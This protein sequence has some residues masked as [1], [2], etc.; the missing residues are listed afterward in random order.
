[1][2]NFSRAQTN[3]VRAMGGAKPEDVFATNIEKLGSKD[4][5]LYPKLTM[6]F[7]RGFGRKYVVDPEKLDAPVKKRHQQ[8]LQNQFEKATYD[9][10]LRATTLEVDRLK[11]YEDYVVMDYT[12]EISSALDIYADECLTKD[13]DGSILHVDTDNERIKKV[14][15]NL[16]YD[17]L[18]IDHNLWHWTRNMCKFGNH[19]ILLD[20]QPGKG[21]CGFLPIPSREIKREEAYDGNV[22]S[23]KFTWDMQSEEF[24]QWQIAHFRLLDNMDRYPYGTS[25]IES[26][27]LIWKQLT[28]AEDAMLIYRIT[29]A[30]ERR[31][32]YIDVGN[33]DPGD[34][35]EYIKNIKNQVKRT[36]S[37]DMTTG[38]IDHK[39]NTMAVDED[40]F[41]PRRG[42]KNSEIDTLPGASNL[43]EIADIE[44]MQSKMFAALK[45]PKAYLTFEEEIN[46]KATLSSEDFRFARTINRFQQALIATLTNIAITHLWTLGFREKGQLTEFDLSL[47]NPSTQTEIEKME[48]F[49]QRADVFTSL[50]DETTLSPV[51][52]AWAMQNIFDFTE[53]ETE[54]ILK[55][56]F[57][58]GKMKLEI[59]K[60]SGT[61]P[62]AME[63]MGMEQ[64]GLDSGGGF[65]DEGGKDLPPE[66]PEG[67]KYVD[68]ETGKDID[69]KDDEKKMESYIS[70]IMDASRKLALIRDGKN[71][72]P[73]Q[74]DKRLLVN[75]LSY[76]NAVH[77]LRN[78]DEELKRDRDMDI[79]MQ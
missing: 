42:E 25:A 79:R 72:R 75:S 38:N 47:T 65:Q 77:M 34:V 52:Y 71:V 70:G 23:V 73:V 53:D 35:G 8:Q 69:T 55:Q 51:S 1:M 59:E 33:I 6:L 43:D 48:I 31:V 9:H 54:L 12:P 50:W 32:F 78:L 57:L 20:V 27:R 13:Q 63:G 74:V 76:D 21:V 29:R 58:E 41:I 68:P 60:A 18:D 24:D 46:A 64:P 5:G 44:Y 22:N 45:V 40:F 14:L 30:P 10:Y 67:K 19:F 16:F 26:A 49:Q 62:S 56:Q 28:L 15:E 17:I 7:K 2:P 11:T 66:P 39:Y 36:N 37:V 3:A 61:D 4:V